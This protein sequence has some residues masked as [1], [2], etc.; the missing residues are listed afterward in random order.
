MYQPKPIPV[1]GVKLDNNTM[2]LSVGSNAALVAT[3][4]PTRATNDTVEWTSSTQSVATVTPDG[5]KVSALAVGTTLITATSK[6]DP[7]IQDTCRIIVVDGFPVTGVKLDDTEMT[8]NVG[9][10]VGP[11]TYSIEPDNAT[12]KFVKWSTSDATIATVDDAG[13]V[14]GVGP[15]TATITVTTQDG[16]FTA[17]AEVTVIQPVTGVALSADKL[18]VLMGTSVILTDT[19]FP[20]NATDKTVHWSVSGEGISM[21]VDA[22]TGVVTV[23]R[24]GE[25]EGVITVTTNDGGFTASC[26]VVEKPF[27]PNEVAVPFDA[28]LADNFLYGTLDSGYSGLIMAGPSLFQ[29]G[30][31]PTGSKFEIEMEFTVSR[32]FEADQMNVILVDTREVAAWWTAKGNTIVTGTYKKGTTISQTVQITTTQDTSSDYCD[33]HIETGGAGTPGTVDSGVEGPVT[34]TFTKLIVTKL[35]E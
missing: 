7:S 15:G 28:T 13:N 29:A 16:D 34:L 10:K 1:T 22:A 25:G 17:T 20:L 33:L 2:T 11:L 12:T 19:V 31:I 24:T 21:A 32:D 35:D 26:T 9:D 27:Y 6:D 8:L 14:T 5:G 4:A 3:I 23:T 18:P 30:N